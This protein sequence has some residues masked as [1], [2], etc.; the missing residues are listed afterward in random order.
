LVHVD[1]NAAFDQKA[2]SAAGF[3]WLVARRIWSG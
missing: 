2:T 1:K 3:C